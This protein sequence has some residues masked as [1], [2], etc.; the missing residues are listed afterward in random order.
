MPPPKALTLPTTD[1]LQVHSV[2]F[3]TLL[4]ILYPFKS[5]ELVVHGGVKA[6]L[7][8]SAFKLQFFGLLGRDLEQVT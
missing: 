4:C 6:K 1:A 8:D 3:M 5:V 2:P 7:L